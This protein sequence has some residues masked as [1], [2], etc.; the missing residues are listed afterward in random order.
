VVALERREQNGD[1]VRG[2]AEGGFGRVWMVNHTLT[3][4]SR[5]L[6]HGPREASASTLVRA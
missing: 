1:E 3:S 2:A 5:D 6:A 4:S